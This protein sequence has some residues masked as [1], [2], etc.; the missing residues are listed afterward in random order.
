MKLKREEV[1]MKR[2]TIQWAN[3]DGSQRSNSS[4][5]NPKKKHS[6]MID[7]HLKE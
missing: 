2:L 1:A 5:E 3:K 4:Q 6:E 7:S